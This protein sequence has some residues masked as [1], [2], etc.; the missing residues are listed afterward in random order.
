MSP[1]K[2]GETTDA[3][4]LARHGAHSTPP[5]LGGHHAPVQDGDASERVTATSPHTPRPAS[6]PHVGRSRKADPA[7]FDDPCNYLG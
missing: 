1:T 3:A 2:A 6:P 5:T 7:P 4:T